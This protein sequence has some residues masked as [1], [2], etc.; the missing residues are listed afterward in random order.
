MQYAIIKNNTIV[1]EIDGW[2]QTAIKSVL[3][4]HGEDVSL[5]ATAPDT[6]IGIGDIIIR[7]FDDPGPNPPAGQVVDTRTVNTDG[8]VTYTYRDKTAAE[9]EQEK[10]EAVRSA[11]RQRQQRYTDALDKGPG[12]SDTTQATGHVIDAMIRQLAIAA[13]AGELTLTAEMQAIIDSVQKIKAEV[14]LPE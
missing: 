1:A 2:K 5:Q 10:V 8:T 14:P 3:K 4:R 11:Y 6:T 9:V 13:A 7:P 12:E